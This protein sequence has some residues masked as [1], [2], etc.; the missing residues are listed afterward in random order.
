MIELPTSLSGASV[1]DFARLVRPE[2]DSGKLQNVVIDFASTDFIDSFGI[3]TL[4]SLAKDLR[5]RKGSLVVRNLSGDIKELFEDTGLDG[6]LSVDS[7]QAGSPGLDIFSSSVDIKLDVQEDTA[8]DA[9][10]LRLSG[11]MNHPGGSNLFRTRFLLALAGFKKILI[12]LEDL[13]FFDSMSVGAVLNMNKLAKETGGSLRIAS[14]NYIVRDLFATLSID[15][16]IDFFDTR[17]EALAKW[18]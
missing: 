5:E 7:S 6:I 16:I 15:K 17:D 12:D 4:V 8:G 2:L 9:K 14:A 11:V 1:K 10:I 13:T 18:E 3:G